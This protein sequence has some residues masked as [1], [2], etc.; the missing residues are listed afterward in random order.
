MVM[1]QR[2]SSPHIINIYGMTAGSQLL[3]LAPGGTLTEERVR[4][5]SPPSKEI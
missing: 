4:N 1:E 5:L 3:E 2:T